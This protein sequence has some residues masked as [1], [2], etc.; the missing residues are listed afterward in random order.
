[1]TRQSNRVSRFIKTAFTSVVSILHG[2]KM[3]SSLPHVF[4]LPFLLGWVSKRLKFRT[5]ILRRISIVITNAQTRK[6]HTTHGSYR[7]MHMKRAPS[8]PSTALLTR[9]SC[10]NRGMSCGASPWYVVCARS[11]STNRWNFGR[12]ELSKGVIQAPGETRACS[13]CEDVRHV[14]TKLVRFRRIVCA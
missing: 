8:R 5:E 14:S 2:A 3:H 12:T 1:M 9:E 10:Q 4:M 7:T 6:S 11:A 13:F